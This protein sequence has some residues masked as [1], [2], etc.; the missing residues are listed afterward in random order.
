MNID[1]WLNLSP[2][3]YFTVSRFDGRTRVR[4]RGGEGVDQ[5]IRGYGENVSSAAQSALDARE[6]I[7]QALP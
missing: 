1:D 3:H 7:K 5:D 6:K 2:N 4:L